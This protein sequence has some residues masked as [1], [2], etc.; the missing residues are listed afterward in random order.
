M[1]NMRK[2]IEFCLEDDDLDDHSE[3][4]GVQKIDV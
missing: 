4:F 2:S 3:F 1:E